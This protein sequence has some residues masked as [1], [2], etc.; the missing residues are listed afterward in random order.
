MRELD[1]SAVREAVARMVVEANCKAESAL[2]DAF[3]RCQAREEQK[4]SRSVL[5]KL[6]HNAHLAAERMVPMCQDTGMAVFRVRLG[7]EVHITGGSLERAIQQG[8]AQGY[9]EGYLRKSVV[10]DPLF[11]RENTRDNAPAIIYYELTDGDKLDITFAPKGFGSE[12]MSAIAMLKPADGVEGV[13][14]FVVD[15]V[16]RAGPNP[17][18][19]MVVGVGIGGT[20]D[21]CAQLAKFALMRPLGSRHSDGRYA[22]LESELLERINA[23]DIGPAGL[24]GRTTALAVHVETFPTHIAG[25]PVAVNICCHAYRHSHVVL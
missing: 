13:L 24:G 17:C 16:R 25:L 2:T 3:T 5:E 21:K 8:M 11:S 6:T 7:Q 15:T 18:P 23:L 12:N 19:P 10:D 1:A 4:L 9:E 14:D 22:A 20:F